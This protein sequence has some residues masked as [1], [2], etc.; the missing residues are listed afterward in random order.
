MFTAAYFALKSTPGKT[1]NHDI[2]FSEYSSKNTTQFKLQ[3]Q[4]SELMNFKAGSNWMVQLTCFSASVLF[5]F[6]WFY[7]HQHLTLQVSVSGVFPLG[8][9]TL[10]Q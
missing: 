1:L 8:K 5:T 3:E 7:F 4:S 9:I 10:K 2:H 6:F